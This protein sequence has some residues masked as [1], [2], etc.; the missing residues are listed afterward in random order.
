MMRYAG[1]MINDTHLFVQTY[2]YLIA[3][4]QFLSNPIRLGLDENRLDQI[5]LDEK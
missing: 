5:E 2:L 4:A 1:I 3:C